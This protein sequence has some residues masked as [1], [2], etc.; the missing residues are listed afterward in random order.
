M[1]SI[2]SPLN[3]VVTFLQNKDLEKIEGEAGEPAR[4][5]FW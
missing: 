2:F 1:A 5:K 3:A 4:D